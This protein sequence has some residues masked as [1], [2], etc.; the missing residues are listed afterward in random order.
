MKKIYLLLASLNAV[1]VMKITIII[2]D[3]VIWKTLSVN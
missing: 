1:E 2:N 3:V